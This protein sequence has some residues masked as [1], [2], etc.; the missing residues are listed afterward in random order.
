MA[1]EIKGNKMKLDLH[2]HTNCSDGVI[3]PYDLVKKT[4]EVGLDII[5]ICDHDCIDANIEAQEYADQ[6][7]VRIL[8]GVEFTSYIDDVEIHIL[9]YYKNYNQEVKDFAKIIQD[10]RLS[11]IKDIISTLPAKGVDI[12]EEK[13]F[14]EFN[15]SKSFSRG[16]LV[17]YLLNH[18]YGK[19]PGEVFHKYLSDTSPS[20]PITPIDVVNK[21]KASGGIAIW[22][23]PIWEDIEEYFDYMYNEA[24]IEGIEAYN[25]RRG[26]S[27]EVISKMLKIADDKNLLVTAGSDWHGFTKG[28][29]FGDFYKTEKEL[30][31]FLEKMEILYD[32]K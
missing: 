6:F 28:Y 4:K 15:K 23:H 26:I 5:A 10:Y 17:F 14:T 32:N 11:R 21:I 27:D 24:G 7:G 25:G 31:N 29:N 3:E 13:F 12:T 1:K 18:N 16:H 19:T 22:A 2:L 20:I 30:Q 9:G 8:K